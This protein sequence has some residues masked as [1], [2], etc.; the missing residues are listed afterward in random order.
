M[1]RL[2]ATVLL[3]VSSLPLTVEAQTFPSDDP[4]I[5]AI[6]SEGMGDASQVAPLAQVL[7]DSIGPRLS[8]SPGQRAANEWLLGMYES[9]GVPA[10]AEEY[11][12]WLGW[13]RGISHID[14]LEPR[15]RTLNGM[16]LAWSPG[17][18]GP[19][20]GDVVALPDF[21]SPAA[22]MERCHLWRVSCWSASM[23]AW[24]SGVASAAQLSG[25]RHVGSA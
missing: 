25:A 3:V 17:T 7:L 9:W 22:L 11:G 5:R 6:W 24:D 18:D 23:R 19:V 4:V 2:F 1:P 16:M 14:L 12:T 13:E 8:G 10:R 15:V 20:E 21:A